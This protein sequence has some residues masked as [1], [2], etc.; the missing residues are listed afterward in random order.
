MSFSKGY[1]KVSR[2]G[3]V[4][5]ERTFLRRGEFGNSQVV[6][7]PM[8]HLAE[9]RFFEKTVRSER[10]ARF[11]VVFHE[12]FQPEPNEGD[13]YRTWRFTPSWKGAS[14]VGAMLELSW[15]LFFRGPVIVSNVLCKSFGLEPIVLQPLLFYTREAKQKPQFITTDSGSMYETMISVASFS[16]RDPRAVRTISSLLELPL[17]SRHKIAVPWGIGHMAYFE[18]QLLR[19]GYQECATDLRFH[20]ACSWGTLVALHF[21]IYGWWWSIHAV[22]DAV[23]LW[24]QEGRVAI[25]MP[26]YWLWGATLNIGTPAVVDARPTGIDSLHPPEGALRDY[27]MK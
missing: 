20:L 8:I 3:L 18:R 5:A 27:W 2:H 13:V 11:D 16:R 26:L 22:S 10:F 14:F 6:L 15:T 19:H 9:R 12:G 1:W 23:L 17:E 24:R 25:R 4:L 21:M 7:M